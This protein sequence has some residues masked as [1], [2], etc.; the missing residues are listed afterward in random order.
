MALRLI[1]DEAIGPP[2]GVI[3][4]YGHLG[5]LAVFKGMLL[6][7]KQPLCELPGGAENM[8]DT[9][10]PRGVL[11]GRGAIKKASDAPGRSQGVG[12][13]AVFGA[14][15][16]C[17]QGT[18]FGT[19]TK[20]GTTATHLLSFFPPRFSAMAGIYSQ[21][22]RRKGGRLLDTGLS[23]LKRAVDRHGWRLLQIHDGRRRYVRRKGNATSRQSLS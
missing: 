18:I 1:V 20:W 19:G 15:G 11:K 4:G 3:G 10:A 14:G 2:F 13:P 6:E 8:W 23:Q 22:R 12:A 17:S 16:G 9:R 7:H 5:A 21:Y